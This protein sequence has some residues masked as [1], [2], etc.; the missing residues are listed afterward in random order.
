LVFSNPRPESNVILGSGLSNDS[1]DGLPIDS[2]WVAT[3]QDQGIVGDV[4]D[5]VMLLF[6]LLTALLRPRSPARA[7]ALYL[8]VYC[9]V[10]SF[11]ETG[12]GT[13]STYALDLTV[14]A[15]LLAA[16]SMSQTS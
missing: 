15:S 14:A 6:L 8:I 13:A 12:L 16:P 11:F 1:I 9:L 7:V 3:Y 2:S 5:G 10:A 4:F